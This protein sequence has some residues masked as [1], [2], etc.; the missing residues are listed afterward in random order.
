MS[1]NEKCYKM[2]GSGKTI[3]TPHSICLNTDSPL[4]KV[5]CLCASNC[6]HLVGV[7]V[8]LDLEPFSAITAKR[9]EMIIFT[10]CSRCPWRKVC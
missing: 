5:G 9:Q 3:T 4:T 8:I 7:L 10:D 2:Q 6:A 1:K